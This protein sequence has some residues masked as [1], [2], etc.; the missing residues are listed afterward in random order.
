VILRPL[1]ANHR[2]MATLVNA[3]RSEEPLTETATPERF[4]GL[5]EENRK[6]VYKVA[7]TYTRNPADTSS[8]SRL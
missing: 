7:A 1:Q 5:L 3:D 6:I 4:V 2:V 8:T